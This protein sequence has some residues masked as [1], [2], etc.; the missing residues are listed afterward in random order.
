MVKVSEG[1]SCLPCVQGAHLQ[2]RHFPN[3]ERYTRGDPT[4]PCA[5]EQSGHTITLDSCSATRGSDAWHS[6]RCG[7][8]VKG[9]VPSTYTWRF[10][11][12]QEEVE[13]V[14]VCGVHLAAYRRRKTNDEA[15]AVRYAEERADRER[16]A[17]L[18]RALSETAERLRPLLEGLGIRPESLVVHATGLLLPGEA[19]ESLVARAVE[20]E[21]L[22]NL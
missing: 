11:A 5:C 10:G 22:R 4:Q 12:R 15:R 2:C 18:Q 20:G 16:A 3:G 1:T 13:M 19:M 17:Q 9:E 21:E 8:P 6:Y 7:K 14:P